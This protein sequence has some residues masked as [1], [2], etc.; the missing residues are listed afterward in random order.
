MSKS[1]DEILIEEFQKFADSGSRLYPIPKTAQVDMNLLSMANFLPLINPLIKSLNPN[2]VCEIG[3]D[4]GFTTEVL[5]D[6]CREY[7]AVLHV[8]DPTLNENAVDGIGDH[9]IAHCKT[10]FEYLEMA[11]LSDIYFIDG[12]H[13]YFTVSGELEAINRSLSKDRPVCLFL[14]DV[15]WPFGNRDMYYNLANIPDPFENIS[16]V[17]LSPV[18]KKIADMGLPYDL[19]VAKKEGGEKNGILPAI[20]DFLKKESGWSF[21]WIPVIYGMGILWNRDQFNV[22]LRKVFDETE[23]WFKK[24]TP[25]LATLELNRIMLLTKMASAGD[26]WLSQQDEISRLD[27]SFKVGLQKLNNK[28][29]MMDAEQ[30]KAGIEWK[31]Q[32]EYIEVLESKIQKKI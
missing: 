21:C 8:V 27:E 4:K 19:R 1:D 30:K 13:N 11:E 5:S 9:V 6:L 25:F 14:H 17:Y 20:D 26:I 2:S 24:I 15:G 12:D 31:N 23:N 22:E 7:N 32:K 29:Q 10:S 18:S 16:D 28:V 3:S